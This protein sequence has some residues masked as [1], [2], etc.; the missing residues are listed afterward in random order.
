VTFLFVNQGEREGLI[1][2]FLEAQGLSV[3]MSSSTA[4]VADGRNWG[5]GG[6]G[7]RLAL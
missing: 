7:D 4:T 6:A 5:V 2:G 1:A 3:G